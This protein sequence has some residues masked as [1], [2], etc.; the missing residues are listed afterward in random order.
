[1]ASVTAYCNLACWE[2]DPESVVIG[3]TGDYRSVNAPDSE[4]PEYDP[5]IY[6]GDQLVDY[7]PDTPTP[8]EAAAPDTGDATQD[9]AAKQSAPLVLFIK[10]NTKLSVLI[11]T[12]MLAIIIINGILI[13]RVTKLSR[14]RRRRSKMQGRG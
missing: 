1:M 5:L 8:T 3:T 6:P 13:I 10:D 2:N 4:Q 9:N 7:F 14:P 12:V 11:G